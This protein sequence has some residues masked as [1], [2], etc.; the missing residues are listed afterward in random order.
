MEKLTAYRKPTR[1]KNI[2]SVILG[3]TFMIVWLPF[4]RSIFDGSSYQWGMNYFGFMIYGKGV[5]AS[6][7]F[8]IIQLIFYIGLFISMYWSKNR[9]WFY[10]LLVIWFMHV[11]GNLIADIIINGDTMFHGD[12]MNVHISITWIIVP[13]AVLAATIATVV[14]I[15]D[16]KAEETKTPW[17]SKNQL[18]LYIILG[19]LPLQAILL[20]TGEPHG[21]TD[22]IGVIITITQCFLLPLIYNP[23]TSVPQTSFA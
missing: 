21:I 9:L 12:T 18:Y 23:K 4:V 20:S 15:E 7:I 11:F 2:L 22:Q 5:T 17:N 8:I 6:F 16:I 13:L 14:I 1:T 10:S 19:V 3:L